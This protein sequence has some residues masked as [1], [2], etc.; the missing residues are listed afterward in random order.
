MIERAISIQ[1]RWQI[2]FW[3]ALIVA[4]AERTHC[5]GILSEDLSDGQTY[6]S[7]TV[8]NPFKEVS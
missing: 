8:R 7:V 2:S 1:E 5:A 6:G 3:D 4:A